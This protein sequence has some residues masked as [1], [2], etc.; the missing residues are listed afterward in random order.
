[1]A[2]DMATNPVRLDDLIVHV[3]KQHP[4]A[5]SL[6]HLTDA[7]A[8]SAHLGEVA[9]HL[10]G[11]FVDQARG[12][13]ASWTDIGQHMGVSKQAAQQRFVGK[14]T[15]DPDFPIGGRLSRFTPRARAT[16]EHARAEARAL[17]AGTLGPAHL[18]LGLLSEPDGLAAQAIADLVGGGGSDGATAADP[19]SYVREAVTG[20]L[21]SG[22][23]SRS[24]PRFSRSAKKSLQLA[25]REALR[26]GHNYIGTEHLL[27]GVLREDGEPVVALLGE[28]GVTHDAA[29]QHVRTALGALQERRQS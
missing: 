26:M 8:T 20:S 16:V 18:V 3:V 14:D 1:M 9:D 27:L 11:H 17:G 2:D 7:V 4:D 28:L 23:P 21:G 6:Q 25:L 29:E 13:G 15:E 24:N 19:I 22:R 12:S 10:I 5:D